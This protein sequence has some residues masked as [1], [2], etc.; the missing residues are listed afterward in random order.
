MEK[1]AYVF[2][3]QGSQSIG[4]GSEFSN[5]PLFQQLSNHW[6]IPLAELFSE[7]PYWLQHSLALQSMIATTSLVIAS[8]VQEIIAPDIVAGLSLGEYSALAF[9]KAIDPKNLWNLLDQR[10]RWMA[11]IGQNNPSELVVVLGLT[12]EQV[13]DTISSFKDVYIAN[14]NAPEQIVIGGKLPTINAVKQSLITAGARRCITLPVVVASH[15]PLL[16]PMVDLMIDLLEQTPTNKP[17]LPVV[18]NVTALPHDEQTWKI[19]LANQLAITVEWVRS[20]EY[21]VDQG[22][23]S[24][25]E[26]GPGKVLSGLIEK[27]RPQA[28]IY[29]VNNLEDLL[30]LKS[31]KEKGGF[32]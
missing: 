20:I 28:T 29:S 12:R 32:Q 19:T 31:I 21:M 11:D 30:L 16:N 27:I 4:M 2:A 3:G 10:S 24:F 5:N 7:T 18:S 26:I 13:S 23:T 14:H 15:T 6:S 22:V 25:I 1:I 8:R 17:N 9:S